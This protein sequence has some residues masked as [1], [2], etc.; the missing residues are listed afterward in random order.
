VCADLEEDLCGR[1][2]NS[3]NNVAYFQNLMY[4]EPETC[5]DDEPICTIC[6]K[7]F[8]S[9]KGLK[10]H[11]RIVHDCARDFPCHK[12]FSWFKT[13]GALVSHVKRIHLRIYKEPTLKCTICGKLFVYPCEL[14]RHLARV[15]PCQPYPF[16]WVVFQ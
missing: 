3:L 11:V 8:A 10:R 7:K 6:K 9:K 13:P 1:I 15:T 5:P 16:E 12:C 14:R 2:F 4:K